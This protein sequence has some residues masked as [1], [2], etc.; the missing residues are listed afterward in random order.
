MLPSKN[1][2]VVTKDRALLNYAIQKDYT[3]DV[4]KLIWYSIMCIM[5]CSTSMGLGHPSL[6]YTLSVAAG[7]RGDQNKE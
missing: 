5:R 6:V 1:I 7:V 2:S 4:G 3:I